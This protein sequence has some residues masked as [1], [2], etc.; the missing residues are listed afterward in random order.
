MTLLSPMKSYFIFRDNIG[1][2][3]SA[4]SDNLFARVS[5]LPRHTDPHSYLLQAVNQLADF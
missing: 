5:L 3:I 4:A 2:R 1:P